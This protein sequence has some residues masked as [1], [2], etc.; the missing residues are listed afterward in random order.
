ETD[1]TADTGATNHMTGTTKVLTN[2]NTYTGP[3]GVKMGNGTTA[4][5]AGIGSS[6]L[7]QKNSTVPL[8]HVLYVPALTKNLLSVSQLTSNEPVNC[9]FTNVGFSVKDRTTGQL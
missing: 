3:D 2:L 7:K 4:K 5:I 1:W 6:I 9:E 8:K